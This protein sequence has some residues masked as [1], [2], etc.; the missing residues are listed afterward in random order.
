MAL[1]MKDNKDQPM[2]FS[3]PGNNM[4]TTPQATQMRT[5]QFEEPKKYD[6][7]Q[8]THMSQPTY[9]EPPQGGL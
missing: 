4:M 9:D 5:P 7:P 1:T 3:P 2:M 6:M 8:T